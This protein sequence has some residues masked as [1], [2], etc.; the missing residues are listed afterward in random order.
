[1][2]RLD[3]QINVGGEKIQAEEI[4]KLVLDLDDVEDVTAFAIQ[5]KIF[6][7]RVACLVKIKNLLDREK[8]ESFVNTIFSGHSSF[9]K[10]KLF[11]TLEK[12]PKTENGKKI[13]NEEILLN[14][15][16]EFSK[17]TI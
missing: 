13:R 11:F 17:S 8:I 9:M 16:N 14:L 12:I 6:G 1:M 5:D 10:P 3:N 4:E 15:I 7:F 2:G